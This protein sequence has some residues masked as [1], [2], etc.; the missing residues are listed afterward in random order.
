[1][2]SRFVLETPLMW[3][4]KAQSWALAESLGGGALI[5]AIKELRAIPAI[6]ANA[7]PA[8]TGAMVAGNV[9]PASC[10]LRDMRDAP[11]KNSA[12]FLTFLWVMHL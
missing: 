12:K 3:I 4:D 2:E 9:R 7:A 10:G 5:E 6:S 11:L 1:M 8:T